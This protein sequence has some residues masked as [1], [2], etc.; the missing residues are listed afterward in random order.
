MMR[1]REIITISLLLFVCCQVSAADE[2][3]KKQINNIKKSS[4]YIYGEHTAATEQ[5]AREMAEEIL[6]ENIKEWAA[7]RKRLQGTEI[8][9]NESKKRSLQN[10]I[11]LSRGKMIRVF[12]YVKK[13]DIIAGKKT[14]APLTS[15]VEPIEP[16]PTPP[17]AEPRKDYPEV[18]MTIASYTEYQP[19]AEKI[20]ELKAA[21]K[22]LH[23][24]RYTALDQPEKY[25]LVIYNTAGK[26]VAV[27]TPGTTRYNVNT[28]ET[29]R[30]TNYAGCGAIGFTISN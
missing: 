11:S 5:E 21:G 2:D 27:L 7:T 30:V 29:D 12:V 19:M 23:Y 6:M 13:S 10:S 9:I 16:T 28:G 15:T 18:V 24:A 26:V 3:V 8:T 14:E 20:K 22:I 17:K 4:S 25:Y 1:L